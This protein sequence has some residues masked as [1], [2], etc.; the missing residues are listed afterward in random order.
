MYENVSI[1]KIVIKIQSEKILIIILT[2]NE[3]NT[4]LIY[5]YSKSSA[6]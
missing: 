4:Q 2:Q 5:I 3:K 6:C 1:R